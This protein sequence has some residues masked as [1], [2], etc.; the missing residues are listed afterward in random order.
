M[1]IFSICINCWSF[2]LQLGT[3]SC[4]F[5]S[6]RKTQ[7]FPAKLCYSGW[8]WNKCIPGCQS[9]ELAGPLDRNHWGSLAR[10]RTHCW[11]QS[12]SQ[13]T[14]HPNI[15]IEGIQSGWRSPAGLRRI[16]RKKRTASS[17]CKLFH[18]IICILSHL[19]TGSPCFGAMVL[20]GG[21]WGNPVAC[22]SL[23]SIGDAHDK[24]L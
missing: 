21:C 4:Q 20:M 15:L 24:Q 2:W 13:C 17:L 18:G 6:E 5:V 8:L 9:M 22:H 23:R 10:L 19:P 1:E 3:S 14:C 11:P 12:T 16:G 7:A